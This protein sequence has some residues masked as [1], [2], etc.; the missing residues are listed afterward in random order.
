MSI[1]EDLK[2]LE[3]EISNDISIDEPTSPAKPAGFYENLA[4]DYGWNPDGKKSA[5]EYIKF[6]LDKFPKR[7]DA[8]SAQN[9][10]I[11]AK[12][13]EITQMKIVL[14]QLAN[15]MKKSKDTAYQ[16]ALADLQYQKRE[17]ISVGDVE[18][19]EKIEQATHNLTN[20]QEI[21]PS[22]QDF[23]SR[24]HQWLEG[25]DPQDLE[26]QAYAFQ[27]DNTLMNK[28]LPPEQ[29]MKTL[30]AAIQNKF[31]HYFDNE[32]YDISSRHSSVESVQQENN[33]LSHKKDKVFTVRDLD[34][35]Q[36]AAAKYLVERGQMTVET[37]IQR[38]VENG[39]L[40]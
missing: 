10:K 1:S 23:K 31:K 38:L 32:D 24:N 28:K 29:H 35:A 37:Y 3:S 2:L 4:K 19:V 8:L 11:E 26:M 39:D 22:V 30:E 18:K 16:Q 12:E 9:K 34:P 13:S 14:D 15:D 40:K 6:A 5:E 27:I 7:G 20:P 33:V 25:T 21:P 17:A 36:K